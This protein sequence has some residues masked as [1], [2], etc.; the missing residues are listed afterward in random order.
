LCGREQAFQGT[1]RTSQRI[2]AHQSLMA[3]KSF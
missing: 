3:K 2:A 1:P